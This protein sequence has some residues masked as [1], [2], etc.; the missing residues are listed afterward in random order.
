[1]AEKK[2]PIMQILNSSVML[3]RLLVCSFCWLTNTFVYYGLSLNSVAFA[4]DKYVNFILVAIVE[5][6]AYFLT[7]F[8][9]D[10]I[11]RKTTLSSSFLLSGA[12]CLAIQFVPTGK[13][14][15]ILEISHSCNLQRYEYFW[16]ITKKML[17]IDTLTFYY[18]F[19]IHWTFY[20][21][22]CTW[23]GNGA[24]RCPSRRFTF[25]QRNCFPQT[26]DTPSLE[27]AAW[28]AAWG[29]YCH[30]KLLFWWVDYRKNVHRG[31]RYGPLVDCL[32]TTSNNM[33]KILYL[34]IPF[35]FCVTLFIALWNRYIDWLIII[36]SGDIIFFIFQLKCYIVHDSVSK[37]NC[38]R[39]VSFLFFFF[40]SIYIA[41]FYVTGT[42][43]ARITI[44]TLWMYGAIRGTAFFVLPGNVG[45]ETSGYSVGGREYRQ[46][47]AEAGIAG[48][49]VLRTDEYIGT[50]YKSDTKKRI[51][52]EERG[53]KR[54]KP[55]RHR[56]D[57]N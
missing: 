49:A 37:N 9:T 45:N 23:A 4:G 24:L 47:A 14:K 11:G 39:I 8:L 40:W 27:F 19:Q 36:H 2:S 10:Y 25:I 7:W 44:D 16:L 43:Y 54:K 1:M 35:I 5:I 30:R 46:R 51:K 52:M 31:D 56:R 55:T 38:H 28:L 50:S 18:F 29:Q 53:R 57:E 26:W 20:H 32:H 15:F 48:F 42:I 6:P 12:F 21:W 34:Y 22:F 13:H 3:T 33:A 41:Y 17:N